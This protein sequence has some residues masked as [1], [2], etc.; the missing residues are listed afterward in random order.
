MT[1]ENTAGA[2]GSKLTNAEV[3]NTAWKILKI[4]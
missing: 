3:E 4:G 1:K 2:S